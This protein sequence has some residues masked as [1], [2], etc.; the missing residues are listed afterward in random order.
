MK[1]LFFLSVVFMSVLN[2]YADKDIKFYMNNGEVKCIARQRIDSLV[3]DEQQDVVSVVFEKRC[4]TIPMS[5]LECIKYGALP[6]E[7]TVTY[8]GS[9]AVV[10]NPFAFDS[11]AVAINGAK[12][13][14]SSATT[15]EIDY[16]LQGSSD[17]GGFKIYGVK[18]YNLYLNGV[19]LASATGAAV[20]SQCKK[21][22]RVFLVDG[23]QNS[24]SDA[25]AYGTTGSEDEKAT[26]FSEGQIIF[27]GGGSLSLN[28]NYKHAIC[29]DDY[30]EVRDG[31]ITVDNAASDAIHSN[32][33]VIVNGGTLRL[34]ALRDGIDCDG[35][36]RLMGGTVTVNATGDDVKGIKAGL[37]IFFGG[38]DVTV[39]VP[40]DASK[41]VKSVGVMNIDAGSLTVESSGNTVLVDGDPSYATCLKCD[42]I[43]NITGGDITLK[44]TG[45]AGRGMSA[46][47]DVNITGGMSTV[48]CSGNSGTY[49]PSLAGSGATDTE[50]EQKSYVVYVSIPAA[51]TSNRPGG[52]SSA[53]KSVYLYNSSNTLVATLTN[54]VAINGTTFYYYDFG[55]EVTD[56]YY[57]KSDDYKSGWGGTTYTIQSSTFAGLSSDRYYQISSSYSTSGTTRTYSLSDVT[58]SY[59][60][61]SVSQGSATEASYKAAGIKCDG[62]LLVQ[63]GTHRI[64]VSGTESKGIKVDKD[65]TIDGGSITIET[66][67]TAKVIAYDPSYCTAIKCDGALTIN[68]GDIDITATGQGGMGISADGTLTIDGGNVEVTISGAGSSYTATTGTDY[69]STKCLKGDVA[70]N[71]LSGTVSC[72]AKGNG[73]KAIVASGLLTIGKAGAADDDLTVRAV[74]QG[75]SLGTSSGSNGGWGGGMGG[76]QEGF[77]AAPKAIKG[78]ANVVVNSGNV[79]AETKYDGGEGLES[80][81][82]MTI[83]GGSIECNTYDDGINAATSLV[84][85]GGYVYSHASNNDGIDSNGTITVNGGVILSSGTN[86][87]EEGF[88]CDQ[89]SFT[90]NGGILL[91][92]GGA[93]S[94]PTSASQPYSQLSSVTVSQGN[95]LAVKDSSGNMLFAYK[96][97]N[98]VNGA[99]VLLSSPDFKASSSH[100][101]MYGVT[102]VS[103][104]TSAR[105][106]GV[107]LVGGN[108]SGGSSK[109]FTPGTR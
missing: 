25:T 37:D 12:V 55:G 102:S 43:I 15:R 9:S 3:F 24:L 97:P 76:M 94:S 7:V 96:C 34:N 87:P 100:T 108:A 103:G 60:G 69:Y 5:S 28:G 104:Y 39:T 74:T 61:G 84:F 33:S 29:S 57:F 79:Y 83:N 72:T 8:N 19:D 47:I 99:T 85:N 38:A 20:N 81:A 64:T 77:N 40:G 98:S 30:I 75:A 23:T 54:S 46:D 45:T 66:S 22:A 65:A 109:S 106:D 14:V 70:V 88:D 68:G 18:K 53:W 17:D 32:D 36:V 27:E 2:M 86:A 73:S 78:A 62:N 91:G 51:T 80:K 63:G 67:G 52:S 26:F 89:N 58:S 95:Y 49:D 93:T 105:F 16:V 56:S 90:I 42:S 82:T 50:E 6:Q 1:R 10:E 31:N 21:R 41:G 4:E 101:L 13:T 48:T 44:A 92:T 35:I 71:L 11:V 59:E 107:F